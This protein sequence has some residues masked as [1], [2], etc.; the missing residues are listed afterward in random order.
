MALALGAR[1]GN[2]NRVYAIDPHEPATGVFGTDFGPR[3]MKELYRNITAFGVGDLVA[4]VALSS[5]DAA[6]RWTRPIGLL[7]IDGDHEY[8]GARHDFEMLGRHVPRGGLVAFHDNEAEGVARLIR[9]LSGST[10]DIVKVV[11]STTLGKK[12]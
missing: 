2:S 12:R 11:G 4:V 7:W 1:S 6:A 5:A 9:E 3:D 10:I 8:E